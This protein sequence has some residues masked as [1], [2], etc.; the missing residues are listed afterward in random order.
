M[1]KSLKINLLALLALTLSFSA[2]KKEYES[3][4]S[5]DDRAI[6]TYLAGNNQ[7]F[8]KDSTGYYYNIIDQG[9][10]A[11]LQ[12]SDSVF[13]SYTFK[14]LNGTV[15]NQTSDLAIPGTYLGYTDRF[16]IGNRP[17]VFTPIREVLSK[18]KRGG[19]ATLIIPSNL[20]FGNNGFSAINVGSNE[21][22]LV[23]LGLYPQSKRNEIDEL[24]INTFE[25]NNSLA[26]T[27]D[28]SRARYTILSP[29]TGTAAI[30][31]N[32]TIVVN[33]TARS[34]DGTVVDD[35]TDG[36]FTAVLSTLFK[37][38]QLILPGKV[39]AG[40]KLRLVL[41]SDLAG[42]QSPLDFDI[43]IVSVK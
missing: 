34:L 16:A 25:T 11:D 6:Q 28:P 12:N 7:N 3:I 42:G 27:K 14:L 40:G 21:N 1:N 41:P 20:A 36:T 38:W 30:S 22:I 10:G 39:T 24:E 31:L 29:G 15:L 32:S 23:D 13:Y 17:F 9:T 35:S 37:G 2:C 33:Y 26:L 43:E 18:L 5:V 4:Q 19:K 8:T